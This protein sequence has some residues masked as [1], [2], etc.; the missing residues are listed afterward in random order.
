MSL[1]VGKS[2]QKLASS[3]S[4]PSLS[5]MLAG[6]TSTRST[7]PLVSTSRVRL[8]PAT[9][10]SHIVAALAARFSGFH[11]LAVQ[12]AG[13]WLSLASLL[14]TY[15]SSQRVVDAHPRA[16]PGPFVKV[17]AHAGP[18]WKGGWHQSP[19]ATRPLPIEE[20]I[21]N[22][23]Q[24]ELERSAHRPL[25]LHNW[26]QDRPF[27]ISHICIVAFSRHLRPPVYN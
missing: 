1:S 2:L 11:A 26:L 5:W 19:L 4:A 7:R 14:L 20:R 13:S 24:I 23:A 17:V 18:V 6:W 22:L 15:L 16:I 10:F 25:W 27:C 21:D 12:H 8:R 3:H 9:F